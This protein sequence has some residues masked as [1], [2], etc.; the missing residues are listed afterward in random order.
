MTRRAALPLAVALSACSADP[1]AAGGR[2]VDGRT[3]AAVAGVAVTLAPSDTACTAPLTTTDADGRWSAPGLCADATWTITSGDA[4]WYLPA[5][6]PAGPDVT[7]TVWRAPPADGVFLVA[8]A[9]ALPVVTHTVLDTVRVF[10]SAEEVRFPVEIPGV[11]PRVRAGDALLVAGPI[12]P[13]L[14]FSPLVPSPERR[15]FGN[16]DAPEPI[17]PWVYLGVKFTSDTTFERVTVVMNDA[18][19]ATAGGDRALRYVS[20]AALPAGRYALPT[21]DGS[22]AFL[23]DFGDPP[24]DV[25]ATAP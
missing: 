11:V 10:D 15:W 19:V 5:P 12:L 23:F 1:S 14:T 2:L 21:A 18:H 4:G 3:G 16:K 9:D 6:L 20:A 13:D 25:P 7:V 8:G 22:R 24:A 17:D